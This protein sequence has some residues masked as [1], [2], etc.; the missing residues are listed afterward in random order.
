MGVVSVYSTNASLFNGGLH[1]QSVYASLKRNDYI[2]YKFIL[3]NCGRETLDV[4]FQ[5]PPYNGRY[6]NVSTSGILIYIDG[7]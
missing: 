4:L 6:F 7:G 5:I 1:F 3:L 2:T